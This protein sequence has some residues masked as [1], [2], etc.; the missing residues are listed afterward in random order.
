MSYEVVILADSIACGKRLTTMLIDMPRFIL[1]EFN[2]HRMLSR[3]S[4]SSR[5]IPVEKRI[6]MLQSDMFIPEAFL[7]NK[8]GMQAG[9]PIDFEAQKLARNIWIDAC[10]AAVKHAQRLADAGVHKQWANRIIEPYA[11]HKV[12]CTATEWDNFYALRIHPA[13]QPEIQAV[14]RNMKAAMEAS[15]PRVMTEGEWHMPFILPGDIEE[16]C[17]DY[18]PDADLF[19]LKCSVARCAR[20]S[21]LTHD[22]NVIDY[23]A[24][25][26][27]H[28]LLLTNGHWSPLEHQAKVVFGPL[29]SSNFSS[30]WKQY[31]K[32]YTNEAIFTG[33]K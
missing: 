21:Y 19:L 28:D 8:R 26:A 15:T 20:V 1:A 17:K 24:D 11:W 22:R 3:N 13:A 5:A 12:I 10:E 14:A 2:T 31:R 30:P 23:K 7:A 6:A 29:A 25:F 9:E 4:A 18:V 27:L 32:C 16:V 33:G